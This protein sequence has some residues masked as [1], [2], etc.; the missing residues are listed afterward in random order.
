M[1]D[2]TERALIAELEAKRILDHLIEPVG[3]A[4]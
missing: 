4:S 2:T 3:G 1:T